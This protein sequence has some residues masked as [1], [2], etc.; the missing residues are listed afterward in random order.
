MGDSATVV[1]I[2]GVTGTIGRGLV[3]FLLD[4]PEI[5]KVVGIGSRPPEATQGL[6][7]VDYRRA[8]VRDRAAIG[9]ALVDADVVVHLAFSLYGI[10]QSGKAL[11][12]I[13][14]DGSV[15]VLEAAHNAGAR[16]F[17]YTSSAAV[18]G[19]NG[20][21]T[22]RVDETAA[23][24]AEERHF[25][26]RHKREVESA[27]T[28]RLAAMP[29]MEWVFFRPCAVVGPHAQ[30]AASHVLPPSAAAV[31]SAL[32]S[33]AAGA[34]L[35]PAVP[36]PP[37][38]LQ[39]VHERDVGQAI[40]RAIEVAPSGAIYNLGGDGMVEPDEVPELIGLRR[41]PLPGRVS[42]AA[43]GIAARSPY[44]PPALGWLQLF[45]RPLELDSARAKRELEWNPEFTSREAL[46]ST[47]RALAI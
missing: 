39:F 37:V 6:E 9:R 7:G 15:N 11:E 27:L 8:D 28:E 33:I 22:E 32:V 40:H 46:G 24:A 2:T 47:R 18:Y 29:D 16:R 42:R 45:T 1:A 14:V 12:A 19:F 41:L 3:P 35:R 13:N 20:D 23:I 21:R 34:G 17:I 5:G 30:G 10:R 44:L 38:A 43:I 36:G 25:Y 4:D 26:S 31:G